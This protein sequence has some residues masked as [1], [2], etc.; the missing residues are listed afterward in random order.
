MILR[1]KKIQRFS[2]ASIFCAAPDGADGPDG[3][4]L[5]SNHPM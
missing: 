2:E 3:A 5:G 1:P 4:F